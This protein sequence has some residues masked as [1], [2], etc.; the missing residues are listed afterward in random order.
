MNQ[1]T[2]IKDLQS[3]IGEDVVIK[4][5]VDTLRDQN[6]IIFLLLRDVSGLVQNVILKD[7]P[8]FEV[9]KNLSE[10]SVVE[11][12]GLVKEEKQA[13]GGF[14]IE[15]KTIKVLSAANPELP[16]PVNVKKGGEETNPN[17]RFDYR[18][19]DIRK[20]EKNKIFK[21]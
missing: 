8:D 16:I 10:E 2:Y 6:K 4:G 3:K 15:A 9:A 19:I 21:V 12:S 7:C 5:F 13:P 17:T 18:W 11:I 14:E 1:R 20:P